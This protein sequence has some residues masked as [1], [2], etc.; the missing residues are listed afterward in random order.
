MNLRAPS[1]G[2][3]VQIEGR[4]DTDDLRA[5]SLLEPMVD[6]RPPPGGRGVQIE[7]LAVPATRPGPGWICAP[8]PGEGAC[9]F[10][11]WW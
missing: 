10:K 8:L 4:A 7:V 6:L 2:R 11:V 3:G 1:R 9:R 5:P